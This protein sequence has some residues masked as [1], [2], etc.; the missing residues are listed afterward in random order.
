MQCPLQYLR[1]ELS[2]E[3]DVL[4]ADKHGILL[5]VDS[6][7]FEGFGQACPKNLD[8]FAVSF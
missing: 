1:K 8:E 2:F 7:I 6:S 5:Q 4:H 3:V